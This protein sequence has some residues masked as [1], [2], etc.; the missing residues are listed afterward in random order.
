MRGDWPGLRRRKARSQTG[1]RVPF[2][3]T[4]PCRGRFYIGPACG[5]AGFCG[6]GM[7]LPYEPRQTPGQTGWPPTL[8]RCNSCR[9]RCLH[10]PGNLAAA[11]G[12]AGGI[13]P[14]PTDDGTVPGQTGNYN[15]AALQTRVGDDARIVPGTPRRRERPGRDL[16]PK[17]L[18]CAAVGLRN[19]PAGA[20]NPA[21]TNQF[22][23]L[24][25]PEWPPPPGRP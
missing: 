14:A 18:R 21:P 3:I 5:G 10:R 19:A 24:G 6:R 13:N 2:V 23:V 7:P 22:Y 8:R 25:Q 1:K 4:D 20:V 16:R 15:P 11:Q 12:P 9:G 17:S